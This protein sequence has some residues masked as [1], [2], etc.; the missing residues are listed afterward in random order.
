MMRELRLKPR[1]QIWVCVNERS[2]HEL[3]SCQKERGEAIFNAIKAHLPKLPGGAGSNVWVNKSLCQGS[4]NA[5]GVSVAVDPPGKRYQAVQ[6][7]DIPQLL[8]EALSAS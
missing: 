4:C 8:V 1:I 2:H 6:I 3:P 7:E 5:A